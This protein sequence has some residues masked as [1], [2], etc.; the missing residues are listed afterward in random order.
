MTDD[1]W[2]AQARKLALLGVYSQR[3]IAEA[4]S[5]AHEAGKLEGMREALD[6]SRRTRR[7]AAPIR[8]TSIPRLD[9]LGQETGHNEPPDA[10]ASAAA[11][12]PA[13][14]SRRLTRQAE[15]FRRARK[16]D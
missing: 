2:N 7:S 10:A 1:R 16:H 6:I 12:A 5:S 9:A 15:A 4:L 14:H 11:G 13:L 8:P 3:C